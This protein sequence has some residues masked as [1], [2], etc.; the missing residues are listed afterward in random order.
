[1][2][3]ISQSYLQYNDLV[4]EGSQL[5]AI[6]DTI[7]NTLGLIT[8]YH[9]L[10]TNAS[11]ERQTPLVT[12]FTPIVFTHCIRALCQRSEVNFILC[13]AS[14]K[15]N[16]KRLV[17]LSGLFI[18]DFLLAH[19]IIIHKR[20]LQCGSRKPEIKSVELLTLKL[21]V[22]ELHRCLV[23]FAVEQMTMF[24]QGFPHIYLQG[25]RILPF[26]IQ[27][28]YAYHCGLYDQCL[29]L[30]QQTIHSFYQQ[31]T[32]SFWQPLFGCISP[33]M[34]DY[35]VATS[36]LMKLTYRFFS[37]TNFEMC[38]YLLLKTLLKQKNVPMMYLGLNQL[39]DV[40]PLMEYEDCVLL[41]FIYRKVFISLKK[42]LTS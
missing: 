11:N 6:H 41:S 7:G 5:P 16:L 32:K 14:F 8:L 26:D 28:L 17:K 19:I 38:L 3:S 15:R 2:I 21:G 1:V 10:Q 25:Q 22:A 34:D 31:H 20:K 42:V 4:I 29:F 30:C 33:L 35:L 27:P 36:V 24:H 40:V 23:H 18:G 39:V 9:Y 13:N 12:L 37:V